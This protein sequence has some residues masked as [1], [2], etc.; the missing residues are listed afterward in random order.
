MTEGNGCLIKRSM[1]LA[2]LR[3]SV[4]LEAQ[5]WAELDRIAYARHLS[6]TALIVEINRERSPDTS[7][8]SAARVFA[9][10][11]SPAA[12]QQLTPLTGRSARSDHP[13]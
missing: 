10:L 4:A 3:T 12:P 6:I 9:L 1:R 2:G 7:L 5:F 8:A 11:N 13:I